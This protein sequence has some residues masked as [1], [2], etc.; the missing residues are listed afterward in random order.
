MIFHRFPIIKL[1]YFFQKVE[2]QH[3]INVLICCWLN[4]SAPFTYGGLANKRVVVNQS[5]NQSIDLFIYLFQTMKSID[6]L[7]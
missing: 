4:H 7:I 6:K 1:K 2:F 3:T 5:I